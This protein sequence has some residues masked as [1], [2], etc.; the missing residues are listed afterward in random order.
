V[1]VLRELFVLWIDACL[2]KALLHGNEGIHFT[3]GEALYNVLV[4]VREGTSRTSP[5][6]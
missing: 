2:L 3:R 4:P 6:P 5:Q 1:D